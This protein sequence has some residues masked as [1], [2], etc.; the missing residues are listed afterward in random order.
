[1]EIEER[2]NLVQ[3]NQL[4]HLKHLGKKIHNTNQNMV[5]MLS[6]LNITMCHVF[7][8]DENMMT[9]PLHFELVSMLDEEK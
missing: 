7:I 8:H 9:P 5:N 2:H 3:K 1:M 4:Q 6:N